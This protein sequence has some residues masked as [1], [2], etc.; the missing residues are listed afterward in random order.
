MQSAFLARFSRDPP[1]GDAALLSNRMLI[2]TLLCGFLRTSQLTALTA[3]K[4][5]AR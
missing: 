2:E 1:A 3:Q 4:R 5:K